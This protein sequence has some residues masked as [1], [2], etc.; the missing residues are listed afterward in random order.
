MNWEILTGKALELLTAYDTKHNTYYAYYLSDK[1][2]V[3]VLAECLEKA[4]KALIWQE[5]NNNGRAVS[6]PT[7]DA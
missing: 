4:N 2:S 7:I 5:V 1:E 6:A 3:R